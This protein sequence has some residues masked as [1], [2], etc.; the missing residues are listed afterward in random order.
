MLH[1]NGVS[2]EAFIALL[3]ARVNDDG[4]AGKVSILFHL[5]GIRTLANERDP[6]C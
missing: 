2:V 4:A 1:P 3:I 5:A 6:S